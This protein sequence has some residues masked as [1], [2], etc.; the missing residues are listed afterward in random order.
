MFS[1]NYGRYGLR[2]QQALWLAITILLLAA[3]LIGDMVSPAWSF[4]RWCLFTIP[5]LWIFYLKQAPLF[6]QWLSNGGKKA[7]LWSGLFVCGVFLVVIFGLELAL[8][9]FDS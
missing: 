1:I 5:L 4:H 7:S 6:R 8:S 9:A 2:K 3:L